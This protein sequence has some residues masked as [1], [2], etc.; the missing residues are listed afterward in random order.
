MSGESA[1]N[2]RVCTHFVPQVIA[3]KPALATAAPE[4][5]PIK[6]CDELDGMPKY[7]VMRFQTMAP[8]SAPMMRLGVMTAG[9]M[10]PVP[11]AWATA[12]PTVNAAMKLKKAAHT[13]AA[14]GLST[15]VPTM[16]AME[17]AE[18]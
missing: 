6:A 17:F 1:M 15:R 9:S 13:T 16:V 8:S 4:R 5:P 3:P 2:E 18:S 12:V 14:N 7:Q 10:I 11:I